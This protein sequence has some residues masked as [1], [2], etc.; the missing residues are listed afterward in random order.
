MLRFAVACCKLLCV[1]CYLLLSGVWCFGVSVSCCFVVG[2]VWCVLLLF[3]Q[4]CS[5]LVVCVV[6]IV[7]CLL[8]HVCHVA[9]FVV[10]GCLQVALYCLMCDARCVLR[11]LCWL[12]LVCR[13]WLFVVCRLLCGV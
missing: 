1:I 3:V 13:L 2:V 4:G 9:L 10:C 8:C 7:C 12:F 6:V 5:L 11:I